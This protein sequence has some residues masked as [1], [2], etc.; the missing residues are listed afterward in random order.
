MSSQSLRNSSVAFNIYF[1]PLQ[2]LQGYAD[3]TIRCNVSGLKVLI[4]RGADINS[5][6]SVKEDT[7]NST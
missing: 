1:Q 7:K 5:P 3:G 2:L 6:E 4:E